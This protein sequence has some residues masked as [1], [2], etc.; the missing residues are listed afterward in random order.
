MPTT[1]PFKLKSGP[2]ELPGIHR[3]VGLDEGHIGVRG[4]I[5]PFGADD[6]RRHRVLESERRADGRHPFADLQ[7][8]RIAQLHDRQVVRFDLEDGYVAL[9]VRTDDLCFIF[10][11]VRQLDGDFLGV[12]DDVRVGQDHPIRADDETRSLTPHWH[13]AIR[14]HRH[15]KVAKQRVVLVHPGGRPMRAP[16]F[17]MPRTLTFTTAGP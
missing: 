4:Q 9:L 2:P 14:L 1:S 6:S 15:A 17:T 5:A 10:T 16:V 8:P 11:P 13:R 7:L 12:G 3:D